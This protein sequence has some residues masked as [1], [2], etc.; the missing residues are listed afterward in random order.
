M[1]EPENLTQYG[2]AQGQAKAVSE[3]A[4][5]SSSFLGQLEWRAVPWKLLG[6]FWLLC[7]AAIL[8]IGLLR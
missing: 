8:L 7:Y 5:R 4:T 6:L 1:T 3:F 2:P